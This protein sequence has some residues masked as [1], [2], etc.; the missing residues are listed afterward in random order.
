MIEPLRALRPAWVPAG[1]LLATAFFV[2]SGK[3]LPASL[4]G[5]RIAG[6]A[7][8][9][10][11]AMFLAWWFNRGRMLVISASLACGFAAFLN[12]PPKAVYTAVAILVPLNV[13]AAML[14]P[15]QGARHG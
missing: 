5:L 13:F 7:A 4:A 10:L 3:G 12:F 6:P 11:A 9:L 14:R 1:I 15:E 2:W 8:V